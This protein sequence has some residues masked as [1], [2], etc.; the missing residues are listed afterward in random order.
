MEPQES[1]RLPG[2]AV[3]ILV[4]TD[5]SGHSVSVV[6]HADRLGRAL[7][8]RITFLRVLDPLL[9]CGSVRAP[10]LQEAADIVARE[11]TAEM[12]D[13][14]AGMRIEGDALVARKAHTEEIPAAILR[15]A[16][17][18]HA[19][20]LAMASRGAGL[21][22]HALLGSTALGVLSRT[23]VPL[24]LA[25]DAIA[26]PER[27]DAYHFL[28]A[29]DGSPDSIRVFDAVAELAANHPLRVT[30][31]RVHQQRLGDRGNTVEM[32]A[33]RD[34]LEALCARLPER[35]RSEPIV[36]RA[37]SLGG[38]DSAI[39]ETARY[40]GATSIALATHGHSRAYH[41]FMGS[42]ALGLLKRSPL[43]LFV[44]RSAPPK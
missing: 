21:L 38:V 18:K 9:D 37:E 10:N 25:G 1:R 30:L 34:D 32:A 13:R 5:G 29:S 17:E 43:P 27:D 15:V 28:V 35:S 42:T 41:V 31:V 11:W 20:C 22:R 3:T 40:V 4:T 24:L 19:V 2:G 16:A 8:E 14:L 12:A 6:Y 7:G 39:L 36:A 26:R 33:A 23:G 44:V